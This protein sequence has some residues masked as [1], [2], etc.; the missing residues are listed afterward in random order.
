MIHASFL[1]DVK[2][3]E[4]EQD[5]DVDLRSKRDP[6]GY[7]AA[8]LRDGPT[9]KGRKWQVGSWVILIALAMVV[10]TARWFGF[11]WIGMLVEM[12]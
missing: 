1:N 11:S 4:L 5:S 9:K 2:V 3:V 7:V 6:C 8:T 10:M 12:N